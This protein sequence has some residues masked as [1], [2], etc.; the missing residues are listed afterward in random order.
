M[1]YLINRS[2]NDYKWIDIVETNVGEEDELSVGRKLIK[3]RGKPLPHDFGLINVEWTRGTRRGRKVADFPNSSFA[4]LFMSFAAHDAMYSLLDPNGSWIK[5]IGLDYIAFYCEQ[6]VDAI[7]DARTTAA[8]QKIDYGSLH[9]PT[10]VPI[11]RCDRIPLCD[12]F[13]AVGTPGKFFVS[14]QFRDK[15][16]NWRL[17]GLEFSEVTLV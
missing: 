10:F 9:S 3:L 17:T 13:Q 16:E 7:D 11:L 4:L 1:T 12:I 8:L 15:Y 5:L 14:Q 2:I 6:W